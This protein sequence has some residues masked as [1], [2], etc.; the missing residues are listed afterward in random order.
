ML[1][2][3]GSRCRIQHVHL[4][5]AQQPDPL[6]VDPRVVHKCAARELPCAVNDKIRSHLPGMDRPMLDIRSMLAAGGERGRL[7]LS[8]P[9][10]RADGFSLAAIQVDRK[11]LARRLTG[12]A[13]E[14]PLAVSAHNSA[15]SEGFAA[16]VP[17]MRLSVRRALDS[18]IRE[19]L[20]RSHA[21]HGHDT[22]FRE[23]A[24]SVTGTLVTLT[25]LPTRDEDWDQ[26]TR[27]FVDLFRAGAVDGQGS[28]AA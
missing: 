12:H 22:P 27:G 11:N 20:H 16:P 6:F 17:I 13:G 26:P 8:E 15:G 25:L 2:E 4:R 3:D 14:Q 1:A 19:T 23:L 10:F 24:A 5:F 7:I 21:G 28:G 9:A 18:I